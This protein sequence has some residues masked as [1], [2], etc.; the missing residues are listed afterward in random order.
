MTTI[1][2]N[3]NNSITMRIVESPASNDVL[4]GKDKTFNRNIGNMIYRQLIIS[5]ASRYARIR[6]KPEKMKITAGIVHTMI[7]QH[8]SRFLKQ[9]M[10]QDDGTDDERSSEYYWQEISITAARDKTSHA[11]R[12]CA[13]QM[14]LHRHPEPDV[15]TS[16]STTMNCNVATSMAPVTPPP[17]HRSIR[18]RVQRKS[19]RYSPSQ[20]E[21]TTSITTSSKRHPIRHRRT[22]SSENATPSIPTTTIASSPTMDPNEYYSPHHYYHSNTPQYYYPYHD[23]NHHVQQ[24]KNES[25][26]PMECS[27]ASLPMLHDTHHSTNARTSYHTTAHHQNLHYGSAASCNFVK[28]HRQSPAITPT[29]IETSTDQYSDADDEDDDDDLDAILREPIHWDDDNVEVDDDEND[30]FEL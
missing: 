24:Y 18:G 6:T 16:S 15:T 28:Y 14:R 8:N 4:C 22:V 10:I 13:S 19:I 5:T 11:L 23:R 2:S 20:M 21:A 7:Q 3:N 17:V 30:T 29:G 26:V 1:D 27:S 9:V 12:F 25:P